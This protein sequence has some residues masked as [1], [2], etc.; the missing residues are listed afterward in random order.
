MHNANFKDIEARLNT[1]GSTAIVVHKKE[2]VQ[3]TPRAAEDLFRR[4]REHWKKLHTQTFDETT[5]EAWVRTIP[6]CPTCQ[7]NFRV[8]LEANPPRFDDWWNW[9]FEAHNAVNAKLGKPEI[10]WQKACELWGWE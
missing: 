7:R 3:L 8:W 4:Q 5:F 2:R 9:T 10:E 6:G 1:P